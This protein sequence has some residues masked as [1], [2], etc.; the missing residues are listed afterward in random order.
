MHDRSVTIVQFEKTDVTIVDWVESASELASG[1]QARAS[2]FKRLR[3]YSTQ[4]RGLAGA[5]NSGV[6]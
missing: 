4:L 5:L 1:A 3:W 6:W 2:L